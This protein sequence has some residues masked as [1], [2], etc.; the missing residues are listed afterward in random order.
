MLLSGRL[1]DALKTSDLV[2]ELDPNN[3]DSL[4]LKAAVLFR[5]D[6]KPG[7]V[8]AATAAL[9]IDP[10]NIDAVSVLAA[11]RLDAKEPAD[12]VAV[13]DEGLVHRPGSAP[14]QVIKIRALTALDDD[15]AIIKV[16]HE[17]IA[18]DPEKGN[19]AQG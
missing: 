9:K 18:E 1:E 17:L 11:E 12:A 10:S 15:D 19:I 16:F 5:L 2:M 3:A 14:L 4:A 13:I 8:A 6:D 7:A